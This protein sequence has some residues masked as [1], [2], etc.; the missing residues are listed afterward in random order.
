MKIKRS[1]IVVPLAVIA[2]AALGS[3]FSS[4][5]MPWY[6]TEIIR[7]ESTPPDWA[8]PVAWNLI[9]LMGIASAIL[10]W[11][12]SSGA[13][14]KTVAGLFIAN[15]ILNVLWSLLFFYLELI[16]PAF[17]EML[18]LEATTVALIVLLWKRVRLAAVLLVPYALWVAFATWL[19]WEILLLNG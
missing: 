7:P 15:G 1:Y 8:F 19:T 12:R 4:A 6:Q 17:I 16:A 9:F 5:G 14:R 10:A 13:M 3:V 2:V 11:E 18:L